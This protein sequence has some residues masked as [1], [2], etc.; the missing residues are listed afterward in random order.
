MK[1]Q[2][3]WE[4]IQHTSLV[5]GGDATLLEKVMKKTK[6]DRA[7]T[8]KVMEEYRKFLYLSAINE[9]VVPSEMVD[10][11]WHEHILF[12]KDY[13]ERWP[14]ILGKTLHHNPAVKGEKNTY[15]KDYTTTLTSYKKEFG[16]SSDTNEYWPLYFLAGAIIMD[17][18]SSPA[19]EEKSPV[20][21][22]V[23]DSGLASPTALLEAPS[24]SNHSSHSVHVDSSPSSHHS[25]AS[26]HS[27]SCSS[28][29]H[30]CGSSCG[31]GASCG[32]GGGCSGG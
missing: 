21:A 20:V 6:W 27:H 11:V 2:Q 25:C 29:S 19:S 4:T 22:P 18:P 28:S 23:V 26:S 31:G 3:L 1:N 30:S 9:S 7:T 32:G 13:F 5:K 24:H 8:I 16:S 17:S 15:N 12:T 14:K 10:E